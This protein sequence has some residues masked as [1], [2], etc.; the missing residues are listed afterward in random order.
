MK[1]VKLT[2]LDGEAVYFNTDA[3]E[4]IRPSFEKEYPHPATVIALVSGR[5]QAVRES[6]P[7][8]VAAVKAA[9][10]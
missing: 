8:A 9:S 2:Q 1:L 6:I 3:I 10:G 5:G 4:A 7:V